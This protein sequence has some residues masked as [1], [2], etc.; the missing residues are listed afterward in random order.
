MK[1]SSIILISIVYVASI[2]MISV[3]GLRSVV[4]N[5][6]I[7]VQQIECINETKSGINV[8]QTSTG[9]KTIIANFNSSSDKTLTLEW[10]VLPDNASNKNVLFVY[11][12]NSAFEFLKDENGKEIGQIKFKSSV[13]TSVKIMAE[14]GSKVFT[15][16][17]IRAVVN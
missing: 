15:E 1:K 13:I 5:E 8:G 3:F 6:V 7:P 14:D 4:Y 11:D 12:P 2:I 17:R 16:I 9:I 10:R